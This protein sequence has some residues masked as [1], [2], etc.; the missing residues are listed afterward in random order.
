MSGAVRSR[1]PE[2]AGGITQGAVLE[3]PAAKLLLVGLVV[4]RRCAVGWR[5]AGQHPAR[6][7]PDELGGDGDEFGEVRRVDR[8][9]RQVLDVARRPAP[10]AG[11]SGCRA[12]A[13]R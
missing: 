8:V 2:R 7:E 3:E 5:L 9:A 11:R 13:T 1:V 10:P 4:A 6:L 12:G